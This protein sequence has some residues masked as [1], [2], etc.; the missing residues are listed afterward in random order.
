MQKLQTQ[1]GPALPVSQELISL[2]RSG[3]LKGRQVAGCNYRFRA[4][5]L[6]HA[7]E[8]DG[9][10]PLVIQSNKILNGTAQI[11]FPFRRKEHAARTYI[12]S[13]AGQSNAFCSTARD[14]EWKLECKAPCSSLFH[15][16]LTA[17]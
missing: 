13:L 12:L 16:G 4:Q 9:L 2:E 14:R 7:A 10:R 15:L 5:H 1:A 11:G 6:A 3:H 17:G 8:S